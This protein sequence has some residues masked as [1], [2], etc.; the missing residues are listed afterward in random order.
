HTG[1]TTPNNPSLYDFWV[2]ANVT[3]DK[4]VFKNEFVNSIA[5]TL[6]VLTWDDPNTLYRKF[7]VNLSGSKERE[8]WIYVA[9]EKLWNGSDWEYPEVYF[10]NGEEWIFLAGGNRYVY[11]GSRDNAV[12]KINPSGTKIWEYTGHGDV[13]YSVAVDP[14]GNVYSGSTDKTVHKINPSGTK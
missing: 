10:W 13:V 5:N 6:S 12:H 8:I 14:D 4:L 3:I 7:Y 9:S 2:K 1:T 11:S